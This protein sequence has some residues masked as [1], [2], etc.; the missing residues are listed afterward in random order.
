MKKK[1]AAGLAVC[2]MTFG[3]VGIASATYIDTVINF[4]GQTGLQL[5]AQMNPLTISLDPG[6]YYFT[7]V[8][9]PSFAEAI[10]PY[11]GAIYDGAYSFW[12]GG[13]WNSG[14]R[15]AINDMYNSVAYPSVWEY[16]STASEAFTHAVGGS[17]TL[18]ETSNVYFGVG[19]SSYGDNLGGISL[20]LTSGTSHV[21]VP[22]TFMLLGSGLAGAA[23]FRKRIRNS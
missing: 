5:G 4:S 1:L 7:P 13:P 9:N 11:P 8:Q 22:P 16:E 20:H 15:V 19:D 21:P 2:V 3:L 23:A 12:S 10:A 14:Y 6:T 17:F 18:T